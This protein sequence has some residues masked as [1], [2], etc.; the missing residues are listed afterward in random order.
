MEKD[1][2]RWAEE[3]RSTYLERGV[4]QHLHL[5]LAGDNKKRR[6]RGGERERESEGES[7][8]ECECVVQMMEMRTIWGKGA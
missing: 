7:E 6:E 5:Y 1:R 2:S 3:L 8:S 4:D